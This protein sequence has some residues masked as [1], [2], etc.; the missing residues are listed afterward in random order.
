MRTFSEKLEKFRILITTP[1]RNQRIEGIRKKIMTTK[2]VASVS[3][4][5][6]VSSLHKILASARLHD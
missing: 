3:P 6:R 5:E 4:L 1:V 2:I